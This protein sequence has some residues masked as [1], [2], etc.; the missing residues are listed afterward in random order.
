MDS[1]HQ[2]INFSLHP[3]YSR[4]SFTIAILT[5]LPTNRLFTVDYLSHLIQA[6]NSNGWFLFASLAKPDLLKS[7]P[8]ALLSSVVE[9]AVE[10][11]LPTSSS[12]QV[13]PIPA[14]C[15]SRMMPQSSSIQ[16]ILNNQTLT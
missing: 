8:V 11:Q 14:L 9:S 7:S 12:I 2:M 1:S 15:S 5:V 6:C 13:L 10:R 16:Q 3:L 4:V